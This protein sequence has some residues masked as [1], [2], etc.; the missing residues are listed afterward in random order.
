LKFAPLEWRKVFVVAHFPHLDASICLSD[1]QVLDLED[2]SIGEWDTVAASL[3]ALPSLRW[4]LLSGNKL[5]TISFPDTRK[6]NAGDAKR[7]APV[8]R[9]CLAHGMRAV[10]SFPC[11]A[12]EMPNLFFVISLFAHVFVLLFWSES[13][14][15]MSVC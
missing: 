3:G 5:Q 1:A 11:H 6:T 8:L 14:L 9:E 10:Q 15:C 13:V 4:L 7:S 2:N 12:N